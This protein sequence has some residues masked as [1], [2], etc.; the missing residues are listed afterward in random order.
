MNK[1]KV[2][3]LLVA[4]VMTVGIV[5][6]TL[7]WFTSSDNV[8]NKFTTGSYNDDVTHGLDIWEKFD[9]E[10]ATKLT[11]GADVTKKVQV[12]N[13]ASYSQFIRVKITPAWTAPDAV[14]GTSTNL[15]PVFNTDAIS[16]TPTEGKWFKSGDYYYYI[17]V[18][19][20]GHYTPLL[21]KSVQFVGTKENQNAYVG[22]A[23][24]VEVLSDSI[25][26][27]HDAYKDWAG[28]PDDVK[29]ALKGLTV[30]KGEKE[31]SDTLA[32]GQN[33]VYPIPTTTQTVK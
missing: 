24:D 8:T 22:G 29:A 11:P 28:A 7:A 26:S 18:V 2:I 5:G 19:G 13:T 20:S 12:Q 23:F 27:D 31:P 17:G 33:T 1:K 32:T 10:K 25:Q 14:K 21:L 15:N 9:T 4:G 30:D 16:E 3:S 6:G